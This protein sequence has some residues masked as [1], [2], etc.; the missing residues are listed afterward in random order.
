[1][2]RMLLNRTLDP[3]QALATLIAI[4]DEIVAP[5]TGRENRLS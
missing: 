5:L 2:N 1:M 4:A 3:Q